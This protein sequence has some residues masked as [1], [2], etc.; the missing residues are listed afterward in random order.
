MIAAQI[1]IRSV[2]FLQG[3]CA[4]LLECGGHDAAL[5]RTS[6]PL[7]PPDPL[8]H[9]QN[10]TTTSPS[11]GPEPFRGWGDGGLNLSRGAG[12]S[13]QLSTPPL[14]TFPHSA[15]RHPQLKNGA[16]AIARTSVLSV[17]PNASP[18]CFFAS[19]AKIV[20]K[21]GKRMQGN[22]SLFTPPPGLIVT[23]IFGIASGSYL[24][25]RIRRPLLRQIGS[26]HR[27]TML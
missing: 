5:G 27:I 20:R 18:L 17:P 14:S 25:Q 13:S 21:I 19:V 12:Q 9:R 26:S 4:C 2:A 16:P 22:A 3:Q 15:I 23:H 10:Q 6:Y 8:P 7:P 24:L 11:P 1:G